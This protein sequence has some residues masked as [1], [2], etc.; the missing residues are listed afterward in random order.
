MLIRYNH[1]LKCKIK[2]KTWIL[3]MRCVTSDIWNVYFGS[4]SHM[5]TMFFIHLSQSLFFYKYLIHMYQ[6][7]LD[8]HRIVTDCEWLSHFYSMWLHIIDVWAVSWTHFLW[9]IARNWWITF[10][11]RKEIVYSFFF[12]SL[13]CDRNVTR[14]SVFI[15]STSTIGYQC[16]CFIITYPVPK[17]FAI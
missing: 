15:E 3:S 12:K 17:G 14:D 8:A 16:Y 11:R 7:H 9:S 1:R 10:D 13:F 5:H 4:V 6:N 2:L